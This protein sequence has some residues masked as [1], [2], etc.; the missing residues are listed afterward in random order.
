MGEPRT[1]GLAGQN[2]PDDVEAVQRILSQRLVQSGLPPIE[3]NGQVD[4]PTAAA[5]SAFQVT[6]GTIPTGLL[7]VLDE[8][9]PET[10]TQG[11][12]DGDTI[13]EAK[14]AARDDCLAQLSC[15]PGAPPKVGKYICW[16]GGTMTFTCIVDCGCSEPIS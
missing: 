12:A 9:M 14:K 7:E 5:I 10:F 2:N 11:Q 6:V 3:V 8:D 4:A 13:K 1:V 15:A 16:R